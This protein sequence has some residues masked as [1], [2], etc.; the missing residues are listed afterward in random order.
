MTG[1]LLNLEDGSV[2]I[3][4]GIDRGDTALW[5]PVTNI[6][7]CDGLLINTDDGEKVHARRAR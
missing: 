7:V 4:D 5:L 2:W 1:Q 3:V 6:V